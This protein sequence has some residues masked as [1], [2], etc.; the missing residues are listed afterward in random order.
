MKK[1][2]KLYN[3]IIPPFF[4]IGFTFPLLAVSIVGNFIIDSLVV[5]LISLILFKKIDISFYKKKILSVYFLGFASDL[6][7]IL[8]LTLLALTG[9][10]SSFYTDSNTYNAAVLILGII[11]SAAAIFVFNYF[12]TFRKSDM[13]RKQK[14]ISALL[15]AVLTAPYTFLLRGT[16][17]TI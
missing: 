1:D 8:F 16:V 7:G 11:I 12:A 14:F 2:Y 4:I 5:L 13:S 17:F 15:L 3:M 9:A 10:G 6:T